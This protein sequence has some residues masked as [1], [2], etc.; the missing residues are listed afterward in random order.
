MLKLVNSKLPSKYITFTLV[1]YKTKNTL[2]V[3]QRFPLPVFS[4]GKAKFA[5]QWSVQFTSKCNLSNWIAIYCKNLSTA[6]N[7]C[8]CAVAYLFRFSCKREARE[9]RK[10]KIRL[11]DSHVDTRFCLLT[12]W[13]ARKEGWKEKERKGETNLDHVFVRPRLG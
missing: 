2:C 13:S 11:T 6:E 4:L 9:M 3:H 7:A 8:I 5:P 10:T 1:L 12:N